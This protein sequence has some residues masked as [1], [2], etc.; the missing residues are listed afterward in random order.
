VDVISRRAR[1]LLAFSTVAGLFSGAAATVPALAVALIAAVYFDHFD[2]GG[3]TV[4]QLVFTAIASVTVRLG[5]SILSR[6]SAGSAAMLVGRDLR[7][8]AATKLGSLPLGTL[9][10]ARPGAFET[11]LLADVDAVAAFCSERLPQLASAYG[12]LLTAWLVLCARDRDVSLI[13]LAATLGGLAVA[14]LAGLRRRDRD[15]ERTA[16]EALSAA[17]F[18]AARAT[19]LD[20]SLPDA[21][22]SA[23]A[24]PGLAHAY[25]VS[26][27]RRN[28]TVAVQAAI[29]R[30][31][32]GTFGALLVLTALAL[33][34][35]HTS[36]SLLI[37]FAALGLRSI[38]AWVVAFGTG[39]ASASAR[40]AWQ[41]I[42]ALLAQPP[43][44]GGTAD[45]PHRADVRFRDVTFAYPGTAAGRG[46]VLRGIDV[47]APAG[48]VT[49]IVG[50]SGSGK[51]TLTR[52]AARFWDVD[53]GA[54]EIG[55]VDVR[56]LPVDELMRGI[57][58]VFQ[59]V[60][61]LDDTVA[62]NLL[63]G[64][65]GASEADVVAA[66]KAAGAHDF[67]TAMP[68]GY[69]T[70]VGDRGLRLSRGERQRLQIAR[71]FLKEAPI[72]ILDEPTASMDPATEAD[73]TAALAPLLRGKTV[74]LVAH[75]LST[76]V[77]A[78][79]IVVIDRTGRVEAQG[80]HAGLLRESPTY[81]SMWQA[82]A[83]SPEL[84][85]APAREGVAT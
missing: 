25:R 3:L 68:A 23:R 40:A 11:V 85:A 83:G 66:A 18:A 2:P 27:E 32:A 24:V 45:F 84:L 5:L 42:A 58:C 71:A 28:S 73:I 67:I 30:V 52:L 7:A 72:V 57:A 51:T 35:P 10:E 4:M 70:V 37:L 38:S 31:L 29:R 33:G 9:A 43:V 75:R 46:D 19:E 53:R 21:S 44:L 82:Y 15:G 14:A 16:R 55:G 77:D 60:S 61:L 17:I 34:S 64:R 81:A 62:V 20:R 8:A 1:A 6:V 47:T 41:R 50:P 22:A 74:L 78:D 76:V 80:T 79:H 54:V 59:D 49:A 56:E 48:A 36:P 12:V 65:P 26:I 13:A 63:L 39:A 69:A